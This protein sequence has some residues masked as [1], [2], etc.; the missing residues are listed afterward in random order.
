MRARGPRC[1]RCGAL[2]LPWAAALPLASLRSFAA[3]LSAAGAAVL[4]AARAQRAQQ[5]LPPLHDP[6]KLDLPAA[7]PDAAHD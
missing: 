7:E 5:G 3:L 2:P 6:H 1:L 4:L